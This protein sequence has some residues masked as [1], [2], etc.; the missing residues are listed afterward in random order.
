MREHLTDAEMAEALGGKPGG[1]VLTHLSDCPACRAERDRLQA[2]LTALAGQARAQAERPETSWERQRRQ[3]AGRFRHRA[4]A[5]RAWRWV[6]VPAA[7]GLALA[8]AFWF[9]GDSPPPPPGP[10]NDHALLLAVERSLQA[11]V[12]AALRPAA[13]LA[14]EVERGGAER[15]QR[16]GTSKGDQS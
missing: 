13:L 7:A 15:E 9:R 12:P 5:S 2:A 16:N 4:P 1:N 11:D 6:W 10:E 14:G 8:A 3:I